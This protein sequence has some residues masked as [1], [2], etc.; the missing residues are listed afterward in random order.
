MGE[1]VVAFASVTARHTLGDKKRDARTLCNRRR[2]TLRRL[3]SPSLPPFFLAL[4]LP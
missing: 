3:T 1:L 4:P 2:K